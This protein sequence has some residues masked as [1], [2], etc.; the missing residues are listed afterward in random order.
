MHDRIARL[1]ASLV[2]ALIFFAS[3]TS[4]ALAAV[5][6]SDP[7]STADE[8]LGMLRSGRYLPAVGAVLVLLVTAVRR[9]LLKS[10][11]PA[12]TKLGGYLVGFGTAVALF[13]GVA[14]A[15]SAPVTAGLVLNA[16]GAGLAA[17]G[18]WEAFLD[19]LSYARKGSA[20]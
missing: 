12:Q 9:G 18:G 5:D 3:L 1:L 15:A 6:V 14:F 8:L 19:V 7:G 4:I 10:W 13:V 20:S 2:V 11:G 16:L 17:S